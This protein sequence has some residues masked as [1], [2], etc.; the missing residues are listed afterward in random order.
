MRWL[1]RF[2]LAHY[3]SALFLRDLNV[4]D[5]VLHAHG[6][7]YSKVE[8]SVSRDLYGRFEEG[9]MYALGL[10]AQGRLPQRHLSSIWTGMNSEH[11]L[12]E[13]LNCGAVL[14][15]PLVR[16]AHFSIICRTGR[17][18]EQSRSHTLC[19]R[20]SRGRLEGQSEPVECN[21]FSA[22]AGTAE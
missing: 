15:S 4:A 22:E 17:M 19:A 2:V 10:Q 7:R 14:S 16:M 9:E 21:V 5:C 6:M 11:N 18:D 20:T 8:L 13:R 1:I 3:S 12:T